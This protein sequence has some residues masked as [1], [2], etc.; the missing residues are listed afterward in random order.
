MFV[1]KDLAN[2]LG[3]TGVCLAGRGTG[4]HETNR[5]YEGCQGDLTMIVEAE[6]NRRLGRGFNSRRLH[7]EHTGRP[8]TAGRILG[9]RPFV[10]A[11][12]LPRCVPDGG[13]M[14]STGRDKG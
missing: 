13:D 6:W 11:E 3:A 8:D 1:L 9:D 5:L 14:G 4:N 2:V 12:P 10:G 7:H